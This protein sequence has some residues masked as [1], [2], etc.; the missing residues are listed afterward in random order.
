MWILYQFA[1]MP[2]VHISYRDSKKNLNLYE[3]LGVP[4]QEMQKGFPEA[5]GTLVE[6]G[7]LK[8]YNYGFIVHNLIQE[9]VLYLEGEQ[10]EICN[11]LISYLGNNLASAFKKDKISGLAMLPFAQN[12][13]EIF[14]TTNYGNLGTLYNNTAVI[15]EDALGKYELSLE[16]SFKAMDIYKATGEEFDLSISYNSLS[17]TYRL[18]GDFD[19]AL[20]YGLKALQIREKYKENKLAYLGNTYQSLSIIYRKKGDFNKAINMAFKAIEVRKKLVETPERD[21][22]IAKLYNNISIIYRSKKDYQKS[23]DYIERALKIKE[24]FYPEDKISLANSYHNLSISY[25]K[26]E[27]Y[28]KGFSYALKDLTISEELLDINHPFLAATYNN[29]AKY[30]FHFKEYEEAIFYSKKEVAIVKTNFEENHPDYQKATEL[31]QLIT[32]QL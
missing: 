14:G 32:K 26:A 5:L 21:K 4:S 10:V 1:V 12:I 18:L 19:K 29:I 16:F 15:Y 6:M 3:M 30:Y 2:A 23:I 7:W 20:D 17:S 11:D 25:F 22:R 9:V 27:K 8:R 13:Y 31:Y 28:K 24:T